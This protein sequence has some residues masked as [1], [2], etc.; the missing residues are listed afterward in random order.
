MATTPNIQAP[1]RRKNGSRAQA[2]PAPGERR[3]LTPT[4][5]L[6]GGTILAVVIAGILIGVSAT[7][8]GSSSPKS[9]AL[10]GAEQTSLLLNGIPQRGNVLGSSA[11]P[12]RL[13]EYGDLQCQVCRAFAVDTLP[14]IIRE[15]VRTGDVQIAF[16]GIAFIGSDSQK[17]LRAVV[18][19][20]AQNRA[21]NMI[22]LLYQ[23][24]GQENS[25]WVTD[26]LLRSAAAHVDGLD[27]TK[28]FTARSSSATLAT[29]TST[30]RQ[31]RQDMGGQLRTPTFFVGR[32]GQP[33]QLMQI[34]SLD[35]SQFTPALDQLLGR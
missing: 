34:S 4:R 1:K 20:G 12:V 23:N 30:A 6:V 19:A 24:Q 8:S 21:W 2:Q 31:A 32:A 17:A 18:A 7:G 28:L 11:A 9:T 10:A 33:L 3:W 13:V 25:G 16:R 27:V 14:T 26:S 35:A 29:I 15:Y 22:D 5:A